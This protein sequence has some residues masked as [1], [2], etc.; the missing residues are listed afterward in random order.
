MLKKNAKTLRVTTKK[1]PIKQTYKMASDDLEDVVNHRYL[2]VQLSYPGSH[3]IINIV[4][5]INTL[6]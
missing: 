5:K 4:A 6:V 1:N 2:G 3:T